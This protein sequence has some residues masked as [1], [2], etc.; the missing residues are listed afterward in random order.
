MLQQSK[1]EK[2]LLGYKSLNTPLRRVHTQK[3]T[4]YLII[5]SLYLFSIMYV[6]LNL[7][8]KLLSPNKYFS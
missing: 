2:V 1:E 6:C 8:F 4:F 3:N 7:V 5:F